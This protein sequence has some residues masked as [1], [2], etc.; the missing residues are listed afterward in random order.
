MCVCRSGTC[1]SR[2]TCRSNL[3][4]K[5]EEKEKKPAPL[6][7]KILPRQ[8]NYDEVV[9]RLQACAIEDAEVDAEEQNRKV[10]LPDQLE[11]LLTFFGLPPRK[12]YKN[13]PGK[14]VRQSKKAKDLIRPEFKSAL[15]TIL[16]QVVADAAE[17]LLPAGDPD[18]LTS[19]LVEKLRKDKETKKQAAANLLVKN[20]FQICCDMHK[21][22]MS[23]RV[24][25]AVLVESLKSH[26]LNCSTFRASRVLAGQQ[27]SLPVRITTQYFCIK[28]IRRRR[29]DLFR[30]LLKK[31]SGGG[32]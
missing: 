20:C 27:G 10:K 26:P 12:S 5:K 2:C 32:L 4:R 8:S 6:P 25:K 31:L 24:I 22:V 9:T 3:L 29:R 23:Y 28:R 14:A 18:V 1:T 15:V 13:F 11:E 7:P 17:I 19:K 21:H 16:V 30:G